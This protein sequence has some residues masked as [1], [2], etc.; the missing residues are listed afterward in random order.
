MLEGIIT[1]RARVRLLIRLFLNPES[2]A[3]LRELSSELGMSANGLREEL[4]QMVK[5]KLLSSSKV[6]RQVMYQ[7]NTEHALFPELRSMV[8][9]SLGMDRILDSILTRLG[10]LEEAYLLDDYAEGHDTG[11][12]DLLLVGNINQYHLSDLIQKSER[13]IGRKIRHLVLDR[14]EYERMKPGLSSRPKL[15]LWKDGSAVDEG[16]KASRA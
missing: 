1:S 12:V 4:Q 16:A 15:L 13:Y 14:D 2:T 8:L 6:G 9:K 5:S 3:Y 7:A 11:I 10:D